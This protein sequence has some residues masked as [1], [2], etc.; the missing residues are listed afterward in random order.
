VSV[1]IYDQQPRRTFYVPR[2]QLSK[3]GTPLHPSVMRDVMHVTYR[4]SVK[5]IDSFDLTVNNWDAERRAFKYEP[6]SD[7]SCRGTWDPGQELDLSLGYQDDLRHVMRGQ[8]TRL[9]LDYSEGGQPTLK[10]SGLN[11]L[12]KFRSEQHSW[13][14]PQ[15]TDSQIARELGQRRRSKGRPG[16]GMEVKISQ[17]PEAQQDVFMDNQHDIVF[18]LM[19]A[20]LHAY[21]VLL[22][23]DAPG[24]EHLY[25]GPTLTATEDPTYK[26]EW[27]RS[28]TSFRPTISTGLQV[29]EVEVRWW[30]R[31]T[32]RP[33]VATASWS[34]K[35]KAPS[36]Q[37]DV[38]KQLEQA[39]GSRR[40]VI[41][42]HPVQTV[43]EAQ[44]YASDV[45]KRKLERMVEAQGTTVGL[46]ELRAGRKVEIAGLGPRFNGMYF[47]TETTHTLGADGY[48]TTFSAR[49]DIPG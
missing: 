34:D 37:Y 21:E 39:F 11:V 35:L 42:N 14:W 27:G 10:V 28:L 25:F 4:D 31:R 8:V 44:R 29:G 46:P 1:A 24:K 36:V 43:D 2:F 9:D 48:R 17:R 32:N 47:L 23:V 22:I 16:L 49:R 13:F 41:T 3:D 6:A 40:E 7:P 26:L 30:N 33:I 19:R 5:D 15:M 38:A 45:L 20:R 12:H 18:L